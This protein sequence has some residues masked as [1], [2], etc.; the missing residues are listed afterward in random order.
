[1]KI[2]YG[3]QDKKA[4]E[5]E[6]L[7]GNYTYTDKETKQQKQRPL[8]YANEI[9][10]MD[11]EILVFPSGQK[12]LKLKTTPAYKQRSL[13]KKLEMKLE[14]EEL[15]QEQNDYSITYIDLEPYQQKIQQLND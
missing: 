11:N 8:L 14:Q 15:L 4:F 3:G 7:L 1:V 6:K 12:P 9:R 2:Y 10:E 13:R 5:L